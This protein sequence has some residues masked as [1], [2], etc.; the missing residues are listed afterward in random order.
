MTLSD[1]DTKINNIRKESKYF[2][3]FFKKIGH[4]LKTFAFQIATN[5]QIVYEKLV[6]L[7]ILLS[8]L[9]KRKFDLVISLLLDQHVLLINSYQDIRKQNEEIFE[10]KNKNNI[11]QIIKNLISNEKSNKFLSK[12]KLLAC[13]S[14]LQNS[15]FLTIIATFTLYLSLEG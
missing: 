11:I 5:N 2:L 12:N 7:I 13:L 8:S 15:Y 3:S 4:K 1:I 6:I 10:N 14:M 9:S